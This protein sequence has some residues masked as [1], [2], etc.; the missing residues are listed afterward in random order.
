MRRRSP[1]R[2]IDGMRPYPGLHPLGHEAMVVTYGRA[3]P[4][5]Y[6]EP[7]RLVLPQRPRQLDG[8]AGGRDRPR[9][10]YALERRDFITE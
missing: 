8:D 2:V 5:G 7:G 6:E 3:V 10:G 4:L 9:R 1:W